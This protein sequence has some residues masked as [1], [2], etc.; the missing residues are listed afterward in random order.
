MTVKNMWNGKLYTIISTNK[1]DNTTTL[2]RDDG[3][4]FI[5]Q[6]KDLYRNYRFNYR[7]VEDEAGKN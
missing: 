7:E 3:S 5:I 4:Q 6:T 2:E 1:P